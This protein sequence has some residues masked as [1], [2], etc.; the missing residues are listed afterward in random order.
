MDS[1]A[2]R[3]RLVSMLDP[4]LASTA[5]ALATVPRHEFVPETYKHFA[6][7][8]RALPIGEG[9]TISAPHMVAEMC[10]LLALEAGDRTLEI[11]TGCGYHAAV[12]AE[13]VGAENL[14]SV[15][16]SADLAER[17]ERRLTDLGY[18]EVSIRVGDG[19]KGWPERAAFDK[20]YVTC[21]VRSVSDALCEQC[22]D[23]GLLLAPIGVASQQLVLLKVHEGRMIDRLDC[24]PVRFVPMQGPDG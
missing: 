8:D 18:D 7:D 11:G 4:E 21:A 2:A 1:D 12:T 10:D 6:Y 15:E 19:R 9:Q 23:G 20:I 17:A 14:Y 13:I 5:E 16:L 24:G 3:E 22:V